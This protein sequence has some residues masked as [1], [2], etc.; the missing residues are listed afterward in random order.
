VELAENVFLGLSQSIALPAGT[1][2]LTLRFRV[3][4]TAADENTSIGL[5][6]RIEDASGDSAFSM[7]SIARSHTWIEIGEELAG[8][9]P[10]PVAVTLETNHGAGGL[11]IDDLVLRPA[12]AAASGAT[13]PAP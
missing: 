9:P 1:E 4:A 10:H 8:L 11:L 13:R 3:L 7:W 12:P 2:R 5:R 6:L